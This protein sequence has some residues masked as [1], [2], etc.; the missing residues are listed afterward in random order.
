MNKIK[1]IYF[2]DHTK[3][4]ELMLELENLKHR[5]SKISYDKKEML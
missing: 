3:T 1:D 2:N 5:L 4:K